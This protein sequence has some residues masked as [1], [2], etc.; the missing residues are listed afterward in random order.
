M[1]ALG[2]PLTDSLFY[3]VLAGFRFGV[4]FIR[5]AALMRAADPADAG[6]FERVN[7]VTSMLAAMLELPDPASLG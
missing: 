7:P 1:D 2:R 6:A 4:V 3:E 5:A